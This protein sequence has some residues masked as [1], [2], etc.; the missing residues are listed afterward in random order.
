MRI[1]QG[2]RFEVRWFRGLGF[3]ASGLSFGVQGFR[4]LGFEGFW[5]RAAGSGCKC[6]PSCKDSVGA[7]IVGIGCFGGSYNIIPYSK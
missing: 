4:A 3:G 5:F 7:S 2:P 6:N 1:P